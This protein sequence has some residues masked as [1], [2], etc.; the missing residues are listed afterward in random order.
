MC[1]RHP[2]SGDFATDYIRVPRAL[3]RPRERQSAAF[4]ERGL[5]L[6]A[7]HWGPGDVSFVHPWPPLSIAAE[8]DNDPV[9]MVRTPLRSPQTAAERAGCACALHVQRAEEA[10]GCGWVWVCRRMG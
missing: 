1:P 4:S 6:S 8:G 2:Q 9:R 7:G 3:V 10:H 5:W